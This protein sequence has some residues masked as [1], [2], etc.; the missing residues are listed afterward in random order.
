MPGPSNQE[1]A[2]MRTAAVIQAL[3][4]NRYDPLKDLIHLAK[5][6]D[7]PDVKIDVAKVLLPYC[8]PKLKHVEIDANVNHGLRIEVKNFVKQAVER[9]AIEAEVEEP[10]V[11]RRI[12][13]TGVGE[14]KYYTDPGAALGFGGHP[15]ILPEPELPR[16]KGKSL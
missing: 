5:S 7:D 4:E 1:T 12:E 6:T 11:T 13:G 14:A 2:K 3:K 8:Y 15:D 9:E 16:T 10:N